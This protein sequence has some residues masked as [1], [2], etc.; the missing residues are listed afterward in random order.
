M[1]IILIIGLFLA[2]TVIQIKAQDNENFVNGKVSYLSSQNVYVKFESTKNL[3]PGDTLFIQKNN[4]HIPV[5]II[6]NLSSASCVCVPISKSEL[7][8]SDKVYAR[9][10]LSVN[11][12]NKTNEIKKPIPDP[13]IDTLILNDGVAKIKPEFI[14]TI[15]GNITFS[16]YSYFSG[17]SMPSSARFRYQLSLNVSNIANSRFSIETHTSFQ[18][19]K[20]EWERVQDNIFDALKIYKLSISYLNKNSKLILGRKINSKISSIGAIDGFQFQKIYRN[21]FWG[22]IA[23]F[24]PDYADYGFNFSLPQFGAYLGHI[25]KNTKGEMLN[26]LALIEQLNLLKTDRRFMYLQHSNSLFKN[27]RVFGSAEIDLYKSIDSITEN[28]FSLSNLFLHLNYQPGKRLKFTA[29]YDNRKNVI[30]YESYKSYIHQILE[31]EARQ[32][33]SAQASYSDLKNFLFGIKGGYRFQ[34][35]NSKETKNVSGFINYR[36]IEPFGIAINFSVN[37]TETSFINGN[38]FH[39]ILSRDFLKKGLFINGGYQLI[40]YKYKNAEYTAIENSVNL[41]LNYMPIK[42]TSLSVNH[43]IC[44]GNQSQFSRLHFQIRKKF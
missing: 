38:V 26:S 11:Q 28:T 40:K 39:I 13:D 9:T 41:G 16:N 1:K 22:I 12:D 24:R 2:T 21:S 32:G 23:G 33:V 8:V 36:N 17:K 42:N 19:K 43:E 7:L 25:F 10:R 20:D 29:S 30:Y 15:Y 34:N 35:K 5:L 4:T 37:Y 44:F 6:S 31:I 14:Q 18:H 27:F 3:Q